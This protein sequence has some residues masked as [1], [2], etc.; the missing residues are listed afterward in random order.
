[1]GEDRR[2]CADCGHRAEDHDD[3]GCAIPTRVSGATI[4]YCSGAYLVICVPVYPNQVEGSDD[5][6]RVVGFGQVLVG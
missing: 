2:K 4:I 6:R 3:L 1:M 5:S